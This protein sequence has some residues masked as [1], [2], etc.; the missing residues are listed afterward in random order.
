MAYEVVWSEPTGLQLAEIHDYIAADNPA[1]ARRV[2][3]KIIKRVGQL[4]HTPR[5]G[6]VYRKSGR[7][8][9]RKIVSGKYRIFYRI[10]EEA[11]RVEVLLVWHGA[12]RDPDLRKYE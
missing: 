9:I 7:Y 11:K 8:P 2:V 10:V 4:A 5:I 1:A 12:R 6:I 3:E